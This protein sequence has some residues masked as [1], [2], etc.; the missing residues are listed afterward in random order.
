[1]QQKGT[2]GRDEQHPWTMGF[3]PNY[4]SEG[5]VYARHI[6]KERPSARIA[7]LYALDDSGKDP[8]AG[9]KAGLGDKDNMIVAEAN[10]ES[11]DPTVDSQLVSLKASG[12]D[13]LM[14]FAS[15]EFAVQAIRKVAEIAW[16]PQIFLYSPAN[17]TVAVPK[18]AVFDASQGII[19]APVRD[20]DDPQWKDDTGVKSWW[21]FM[22]KYYA[23]GD[24]HDISVLSGYNYAQTIA[25]TL[26]QCKDDLSRANVMKQAENIKGLSLDMLLPGIAVNTSPT[27]HYP[28]EQMQLARF[29]GKRWELFGDVID[30]SLDHQP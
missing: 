16:K 5:A 11:G 4:Q 23:K 17:S 12:A 14:L 2:F 24:Q 15:N 27:D 6:L 30:G 26:Q 20:P 1:M 8:L 9:R 19:T 22:K 25:Y 28:V 29:E 21:A 3:R 7:V 13:V 10:Y 18:L